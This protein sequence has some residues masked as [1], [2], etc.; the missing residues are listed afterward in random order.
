MS[1]IYTSDSKFI[2][3]ILS[4]TTNFEQALEFKTTSCILYD[5]NHG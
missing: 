5:L 3:L 4:K 2:N 1:T